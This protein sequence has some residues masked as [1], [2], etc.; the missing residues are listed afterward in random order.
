MLYILCCRISHI[1]LSRMLRFVCFSD[2]LDVINKFVTL[3]REKRDH[4]EDQQT[5]IRTGLDKLF[6][7]QDQVATLRHEMVEKE[8]VLRSK[9]VEANTKLTQMLSKQKEAEERKTTL[10][11]LK[12]ELNQ[13]EEQIRV[14]KETVQSELNEA[15]P[16]LEAAKHS[17][18]NIRKAQLDEVRALARPP[19]AVKLTLEMVSLMIGEGSKEWGEIRKVIRGDEFIRTVVEF[20]PT[21]LTTK[22]VCLWLYHILIF[23]H[24]ISVTVSLT[25]SS[26][27]SSS[28]CCSSSQ[29]R[30]VQDEYLSNPELN[31]DSVDRASKACGPL[32]QWASSQI[33]FATILKKIAP[34]RDEVAAFEGQLS[35]LQNRTRT[36]ETEV[37][38]LEAAILQYKAEYASAIGDT[39]KIRSEME[40]VS[41]KVRLRVLYV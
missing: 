4:L 27:S 26:S 10:E 1:I 17:V 14:R 37:G 5:H 28:S 30:Q 34:L 41:E 33:K 15:L 19:N 9:D 31:Y 35:Q 6:E 32:Y 8:A 22:Q 7:T 25:S 38:E 39:Q 29:A 18:H 16:A 36:A 23:L 3:E 24:S 21:K 12:Q 13:Q 11:T 20:E 40:S 2:Y